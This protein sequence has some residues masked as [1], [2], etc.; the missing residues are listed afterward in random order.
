MA[1]FSQKVTATPLPPPLKDSMSMMSEVSLN[2]ITGII[3]P[4][5]FK[6]LHC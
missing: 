4:L 6:S 3:S 1:H 5:D 2:I